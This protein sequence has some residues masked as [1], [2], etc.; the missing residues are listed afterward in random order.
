[1]VLIKSFF[2]HFIRSQIS[3]LVKAWEWTESDYIIHCLPLH[4]VHG[5]VNVL[6]C[7]LWVG[8]TCHMLLKFTPD[9][10]R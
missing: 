7:P 3:S 10:V 5:I 1:M 6:L 4:H 8:A 2:Y 9:Q